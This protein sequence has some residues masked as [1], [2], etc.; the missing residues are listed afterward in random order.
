LAASSASL[1]ARPRK[2][3]RETQF[4]GI[5]SCG[6]EGRFDRGGG[7]KAHPVL[8]R[9]GAEGEQGVA[10]LQPLLGGLRVLGLVAVHNVLEGALLSLA[11]FR[12]ICP[13]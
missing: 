3:L 5:A 8:A 7:A 4:S 11:L 1:K 13:Q 2:V 10:V 6:R 9:E 12:E